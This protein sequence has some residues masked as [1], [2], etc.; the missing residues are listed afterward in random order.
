M[1]AFYEASEML[2]AWIDNR[3]TRR[4]V[5]ASQ[6]QEGMDVY[7]MFLAA[8]QKNIYAVLPSWGTVTAPAK[9]VE[10]IRVQDPV[11]GEERMLIQ[12]CYVGC[13]GLSYDVF[14]VGW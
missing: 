6:V 12:P 14:A 5:D 1:D 10:D 7:V 2:D 11:S 8:S 13:K 9:T 3:K 4:L